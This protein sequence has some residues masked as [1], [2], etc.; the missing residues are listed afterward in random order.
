ML[1]IGKIFLNKI[2]YFFLS[3]LEELKHLDSPTCQI[4]KV[5][6]LAWDLVMNI[7]INSNLFF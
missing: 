1:K 2:I 6:H 7:L 3:L 5:G 4:K